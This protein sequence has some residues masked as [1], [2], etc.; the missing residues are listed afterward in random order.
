MEMIG[1]ED[2][3]Y[4]ISWIGWIIVTFFDRKNKNRLY[5]TIFIFFLIICSQIYLKISFFEVNLSGLFILSF[6]IISIVFTEQSKLKLIFY[7]GIIGMMYAIAHFLTIQYPTLINSF[8]EISIIITMLI[9]GIIFTT[10]YLNMI[11]IYIVG[12][13]QGDLFIRYFLREYELVHIIGDME[14]L[15]II[16]IGF[17]MIYFFRRLVKLFNQKV[18]ENNKF[19]KGLKVF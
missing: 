7:S 10:G 15:R 19:E 1:G 16:S 17:A 6:G 11:A 18:Q 14:Y 5:F 3:F 4:L 8:Y 9:F 12:I 13:F 2:M